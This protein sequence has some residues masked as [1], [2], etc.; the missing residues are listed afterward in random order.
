M[1]SLMRPNVCWCFVCCVIGCFAVSV[2]FHLLPAE[3]QVWGLSA[4]PGL[5]RAPCP[6]ACKENVL[7]LTPLNVMHGFHSPQRP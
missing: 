7:S 3:F 4:H 1:F 6:T 2:L 5:P